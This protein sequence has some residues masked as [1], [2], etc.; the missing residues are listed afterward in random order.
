MERWALKVEVMEL[1]F[2]QVGDWKLL[3]TLRQ[4]NAK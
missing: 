1:G 4:V 2:S 3:K